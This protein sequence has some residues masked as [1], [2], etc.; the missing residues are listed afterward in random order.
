MVPAPDE[1]LPR[2]GREPHGLALMAY[3]PRACVCNSSSGFHSRRLPLVFASSLPNLLFGMTCAQRHVAS[4]LAGL[5]RWAKTAVPGMLT[6]SAVGCESG[7]LIDHRRAERTQV[8]P[9]L[10]LSLTRRSCGTRRARCPERGSRRRRFAVSTRT[11]SSAGVS[12]RCSRV[13]VLAR[14]SRRVPAGEPCRLP[15][16]IFMSS[17][18]M[19]S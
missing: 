9:W 6:R 5:E 1:C 4:A 11:S 7:W 19:A 18:S 2:G 16:S 14:C 17:I 3:S 12:A 10:R 8:R 15:G 13:A